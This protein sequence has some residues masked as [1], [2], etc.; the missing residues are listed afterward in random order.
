VPTPAEAGVPGIRVPECEALVAAV[1]R[2]MRCDRVPAD[3]KQRL[4][5]GMQRVARWA[6][7]PAG[8][9]ADENLARAAATCV[10]ARDD[11]LETMV[12]AGCP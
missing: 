1:A 5:V 6:T 8:A 9:D 4:Q 3:M 11:L 7:V 2:F 10:E 12:V